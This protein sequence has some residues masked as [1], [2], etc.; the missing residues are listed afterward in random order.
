MLRESGMCDMVVA[1]QDGR[2]GVQEVCEWETF[3]RWSVEMVETK[4]REM[5]K[6]G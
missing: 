1:W 6:Q 4:L 2:T 5:E 3:K